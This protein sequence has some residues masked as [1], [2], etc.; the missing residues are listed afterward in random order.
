MSD[1][2]TIDKNTLIKWA[3]VFIAAAA[4][5]FIPCNEIYSPEVKKFLFVTALGILLVAFELIDLMAVSM[6]FPIGYILFG[7]APDGFGLRRL[8]G[9]YAHGGYRRLHD[10]QRHGPNWLT[11]TDCLQVHL[12]GR[13][14]LLRPALRRADC[15]LH[16]E[17]P[18]PAATHGLSWR[19]SPSACAK[20]LTWVKPW[21]RPSS[22]SWALYRPARPAYSF[23]RRTSCPSYLTR[24]NWLAL[25]MPQPGFNISP[26]WLL[27]CCSFWYW[28]SYC[29][30]FIN[31]QKK[32]A[33]QRIL[34]G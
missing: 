13:R 6:M 19:P 1:S 24:P 25:P 18:P 9:H 31:R 4:I 17:H 14:Q 23:I 20:P 3:V 34:P 8:A 28:C 11:K 7:L 30:K 2:Q 10:C 29:L 12:I 27:T 15:R 16:F 26:K 21:T 33:G 22:C 32:I 5:W